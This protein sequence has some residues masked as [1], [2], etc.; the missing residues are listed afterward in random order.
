MAAL[1]IPAL[2]VPGGVCA[3]TTTT[4]RW[5]GRGDAARATGAGFVASTVGWGSGAGAAATMRG[6][7]P[8]SLRPCPLQTSIPTNSPP[9]N[10]KATSPARCRV[11][12]LTCAVRTAGS[13]GDAVRATGAVTRPLLLVETRP[14]L[15]PR[16]AET[17]TTPELRRD[18]SSEIGVAGLVAVRSKCERPAARGLMVPGGRVVRPTDGAGS[19]GRTEPGAGEGK[20]TRPDEDGSASPP[21]GVVVGRVGAPGGGPTGRAAGA[22]VKPGTG[23]RLT[24]LRSEGLVAVVRT[25]GRS[26]I[27]FMP[28]E[29]GSSAAS[30]TSPILSSSASSTTEM[31]AGVRPFWS[32]SGSSNSAC[33]PPM[34]APLKSAACAPAPWVPP[35]IPGR[36]PRARSRYSAACTFSACATSSNRLPTCRSPAGCADAAF[37]SKIGSSRIGAGASVAPLVAGSSEDDAATGEASS[38]RCPN[39]G[40]FKPSMPIPMRVLNVVGLA[41]VGSAGFAPACNRMAS[42]ESSSAAPAFAWDPS[43]SRPSAGS[44]APAGIADSFWSDSAALTEGGS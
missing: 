14:E 9:A 7:G 22:A 32:S 26:S 35:G 38:A 40:S 18:A 1:A 43:A 15:P 16:R 8:D 42:N 41:R 25:E 29:V 24:D 21:M 12:S 13:D 3:G 20:R 30:P 5:A 44:G 33:T 31:T 39:P 17:E 37:A 28:T 27:G 10:V 36:R 11:A 23:G 4:G 34:E 19:V 6:A 2:A